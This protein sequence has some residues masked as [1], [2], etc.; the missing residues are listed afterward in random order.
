MVNPPNHARLA[1]AEIASRKVL[2][3]SNISGPP[4][5]A[6]YLLTRYAQVHW[7]AD[8]QEEGFCV[9]HAGYFHVFLN[10]TMAPNRGNF[11]YGHELGHLVLNHLRINQNRM[12]PAAVVL[13]KSEANHFSATLLMP[14]DWVQKFATGL[15]QTKENLK[16]LARQFN[17]PPEAMEKRL[18]ELGIWE[19]LQPPAKN[20]SPISGALLAYKGIAARRRQMR[21]DMH[22]AE[23]EETCSCP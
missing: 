3:E 17:V 21:G 19:N 7:F 9:E 11:K 13:I 5:S 16:K 22:G 15:S 18:Y 6:K 10:S 2:L 14:D 1:L 12:N 4:V 8:D 20:P 23:K